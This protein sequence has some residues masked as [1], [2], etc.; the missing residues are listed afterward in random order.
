MSVVQL[1]GQEKGSEEVVA[2]YNAIL[3]QEVDGELRFQRHE[4]NR[5]AGVIAGR[6]FGQAIF[7]LVNM[8]QMAAAISSNGH[9]YISIFWHV[10]PARA[11]GFTHWLNSNDSQNSLVEIDKTG[12]KKN[13][14]T[15]KVTFSRMPFLTALMEFMATALGFDVILNHLGNRDPGKAANAIT[16]EFNYWLNQYMPSAHEQ[17]KYRIIKEYLDRQI[18]TPTLDDSVVLSLWK[19]ISL[20][21]EDSRTYKGVVGDALR[22]LRAW[23]AACNANEMGMAH[24]L[25][26]DREAGEVDVDA[27]ANLWEE[28]VNAEEDALSLLE[29]PPLNVIKLLT[30]TE[31]KRWGKFAGEG[32]AG[33]ALPL[34]IL[35]RAWV[36][37]W[38]GKISIAGG[39]SIKIEVLESILTTG[40]K[41]SFADLVGQLDKLQETIIRARLTVF[42]HLWQLDRPETLHCLPD[43]FPEIDLS[44]MAQHLKNGEIKNILSILKSNPAQVPNLIESL[45]KASKTAKGF[46]RQGLG[47]EDVSDSKIQDALVE[48]DTILT[49]LSKPLKMYRNSIITKKIDVQAEYDFF[50]KHFQNIYGDK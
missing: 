4:M 26:T 8:A 24:P 9:D 30:S 35:R 23:E 41:E 28:V 27:G 33:R 29:V 5:L 12:L 44:G 6:S 47:L 34:S 48:A 17:N 14:G 19:E 31:K 36:G 49:K 18:D 45:N 38:Q 32:K 22:F 40:P 25:G 50:S 10:N 2:L 1:F 11:N 43:L 3:E 46:Q 20:V 39:A 21:E 42:Y 15:F 7:E 16:R 37:P 13:D